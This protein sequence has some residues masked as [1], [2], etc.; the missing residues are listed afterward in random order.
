[1]V[2]IYFPKIKVE[3]DFNTHTENNKRRHFFQSGRNLLLWF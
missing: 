3:T 2:V 1:M